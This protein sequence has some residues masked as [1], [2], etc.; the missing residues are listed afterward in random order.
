MSSLSPPNDKGSCCA[1]ASGGCA[2]ESESGCDC[3]EWWQRSGNCGGSRPHCDKFVKGLEGVSPRFRKKWCALCEKSAVV[4]EDT[5]PRVVARALKFIDEYP[6]KAELPVSTS[7]DVRERYVDYIE[8]C[9]SQKEL[10]FG[11]WRTQ[12]MSEW[13]PDAPLMWVDALVV[14][15][16]RYLSAGETEL[17]FTNEAGEEAFGASEL[18]WM[19]SRQRQKFAE[20]HGFV[21]RIAGGSMNDVKNIDVDEEVAAIDAEF[22]RPLMGL[23]TLSSSAAPDDV[24]DAPGDHHV[25]VGDGLSAAHQTL[26]NKMNQVDCRDWTY[27]V[28][29]EP[30]G[31]GDRAGVNAG[32]G[33]LH[34]VVL[35]DTDEDVSAVRQKLRAVVEK[36]VDTASG[37]GAEAH[38]LDFTEREWGLPSEVPDVS[39]CGC[40]CHDDDVDDGCSGSGCDECISA[41]QVFEIDPESDDID[42]AAAYVASYASLD[43]EKEFIDRCVEFQA[44]A[45]MLDAVNKRAWR[46]GELARELAAVDLCD[47]R[48][49]SS[50]GHQGSRHG[51][52]VVPAHKCGE[53]ASDGLELVCDYCGESHGIEDNR[54]DAALQAARRQM[55]VEVDVVSEEVVSDGGSASVV[56]AAPDIGEFWSDADVGASV[57]AP[58]VSDWVA[59]EIRARYGGDVNVGDCERVARELN[60]RGWS[61]CEEVV[62]AALGKNLDFEESVV[63]ECFAFVDS[64]FGDAG[65]ADLA[66]VSGRAVASGA[67][68]SPELVASCLRADSVEAVLRECVSDDV[69]TV[70]DVDDVILEYIR[71]EYSGGRRSVAGV[72]SDLNDRAVRVT[73]EIVA[74]ALGFDAGSWSVSFV[75]ESDA[76]ESDDGESWSLDGIVRNRG[77]EDEEYSLAGSSGVNMIEV[78]DCSSDALCECGV[79]SISVD[80]DRYAGTFTDRLRLSEAPAEV[81]REGDVRCVADEF[82]AELL[83]V[84]GFDGPVTADES[85]ELFADLIAAGVPEVDR[86]SLMFD[87]AVAEYIEPYHG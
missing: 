47:K 73:P 9:W 22:D 34:A 38:D 26:R 24:F 10:K 13:V 87:R 7:V 81:L 54:S 17:H 41:C 39:D 59:D 69:V 6:E 62:R 11:E 70:D 80:V 50:D 49:L 43:T 53:T 15:L 12:Q 33:H 18:R 19:R 25:D 20:M 35:I 36:H 63:R 30:H 48:G 23:V 16:E 68:G 2:C 37:A 8:R 31:T 61:P 74:F 64:E 58:V 60:D 3:S 46:R 79:D 42:N 45:S 21:R 77:T 86:D 1:D 66:R 83:S 32:F 76:D 14:T 44:W 56:D 78:C 52:V 5:D 75:R 71:D 67:P 72:V 28:R 57:G 51:G 85:G 29:F 40:D 65:V 55:G 4:T 27:D 82:D 84:P